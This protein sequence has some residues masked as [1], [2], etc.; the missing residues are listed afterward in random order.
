MLK[1]PACFMATIML[2]GL[3]S[4]RK[5]RVVNT[6]FYYWKTVY[7][8]NATE[9]QYF[10][11]LRCKKLYIRI[12]DV[13]IGDN[14]PV[15][16][17]PVT[18]K[19]ALPDSVQLV[20]VV[21]VV[22]DIL[23]HQT[24]QQLKDLAGKIVYYV[25]GRIKTSGKTSYKEL[26]LDCDWTRTTRDNYFYLL[27]CIKTNA[28]LRNIRLSVTLRLHQLKNQKS[29]GIPPVDRVMLMCYNMGNLRKYGSQNSILEQSELEKYVGKNLSNYPMPV[30]VGLPLFS[31]AVVFRQKQ[32]AG[33]SKRLNQENFGDQQSFI[34]NGNSLY[35]LQKDLP[36]YGLLRG[37]EVRWESLSASQLQSAASYMQKFISSDTVNIIYFHLDEPTLKHYTYEELEKTTAV[38][39]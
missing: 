30:D 34:A 20:P 23:K 6:S 22:N 28:G 31:W 29:S 39:R 19:A 9:R 17:S 21:F 5:N 11:T 18:F 33:V 8:T 1:V 27:N 13:D 10:N 14:G 16:L 12:M 25:N 3:V 26:Q 37:D 7:D 2:L 32:Y 15:P 4:C 35:K 24:H 38:F 36:N